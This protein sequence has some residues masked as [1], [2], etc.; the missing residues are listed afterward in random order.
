M[1]SF[2][3]KTPPQQEMP[4]VATE[5]SNGNGHDVR[6]EEPDPAR[7]FLH[8][9]TREQ[10]A[11]NAAAAAHQAAL[12]A[13]GMAGEML[14][15]ATTLER[16]HKELTEEVRKTNGRID[17]VDLTIKGLVDQLTASTTHLASELGDIARAWNARHE[18]T[19]K[20]VAATHA[21]M[22]A[23]SLQQQLPTVPVPSIPQRS[24]SPDPMRLK[25]DSSQAFDAE[26]E[27]AQVRRVGRTVIDARGKLMWAAI[28]AFVGTVSA[29]FGG[30]A[31][32]EAKH[33]SAPLVAPI[34]HP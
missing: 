12:Q 32:S 17:A 24:I 33:Q 20:T 5:L 30:Y 19:E 1:T 6:A 21:M 27:Q 25:L 7:P 26:L 8:A 28:L 2:D 22:T 11:A 29:A 9:T 3:D 34:S 4:H 13:A 16:A 15:R 18:I 31:V 23:M 10:I 14:G